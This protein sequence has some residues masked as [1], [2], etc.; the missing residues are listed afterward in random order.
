MARE[1]GWSGAG[2][3]AG[4]RRHALF[5]VVLAGGVALRVLTQIA[6]W[7]AL[8]FEDSYWY[9]DNVDELDPGYPR[10]IGYPL[11]LRLLLQAPDFVIIPATQ[12]L[13]GLGMGMIIY[14]LLLRWGA[15]RWLAALAAVPVLW[16]GYQLQ[17]EHQPLS[18]PWFQALVL[19]ALALLAWRPST[20]PAVPAAALAGLLLGASVAVR[21]IGQPLVIPAVLAVL[22][23]ARGWRRRIGGALAL[24]LAFAIPLGGYM[25]YYEHHYGE[26]KLTD[27]N[28][29]IQYARVARFADCDRI[30]SLPAYER[31]LCPQRPPAQRLPTN[32]YVWSPQSPARQYVPPPGMDKTEVVTDFT[33]RVIL[34]QPVDFLSAWLHDFTRG[35]YPTK[36]T[37]V[38][39][40]PVDMWHF[41]MEFRG[42]GVGRD[43]N[44]TVQ[45]FGSSGAYLNEP[46]A[47]FLRSYQLTV[48][49]T[50]GTILGVALVAGAAG[51]VGAGQAR[52]SGMRGVCFLFT[53]SGGGLLLA[54]AA[55]EFSWRYQLPGLVLLPVAGV[56][57]L[58]AMFGGTREP[59]RPT[60]PQGAGRPPGRRGDP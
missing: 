16:S 46:L 18:D 17:I 45:A 9:L 33:R 24:A 40:V 59:P 60:S 54:S 11:V 41:P 4:A 57:G 21:L 26:Y 36:T 42:W 25:A 43:P 39:E 15:W 10:P 12:H 30:P 48:G 51:A 8:F 2:L 44:A 49:Y 28:G 53:A 14:V 32:A 6:Y 27:M 5:L 22:A 19:L 7:P 35:F 23:M 34:H 31:P 29:V 3:R 37:H 20:G 52:R 1:L 58:V 38:G 47:R 55:F 50:P 56:L 13:L